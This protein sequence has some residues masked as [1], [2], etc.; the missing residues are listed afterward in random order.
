MASLIKCKVCKT[1]QPPANFKSSRVTGR[2]KLCK[3]CRDD[4]KE[5]EAAARLSRAKLAAKGILCDGC[6]LG[7]RT[8]RDFSNNKHAE[9]GQYGFF[10]FFRGEYLCETC[11][12][13]PAREPW[14][15]TCGAPAGQEPD[16]VFT[17]G[18]MY[19]T[20]EEVRRWD[21]NLAALKERL[22]SR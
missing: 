14:I 15:Y 12:D 22:R 2:T 13:K 9:H 5:R 18:E 20:K 11:L 17:D 4:V 21:K 19:F 8:E 6:G 16:P 10:T 3:T 7:A 1:E